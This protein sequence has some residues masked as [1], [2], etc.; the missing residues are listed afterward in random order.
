MRAVILAGGLGTRMAG[1]YPGLPKPLIPVGGK[2]VL[3]RQIETLVRQGITEITLVTGYMADRVASVFGDGS[4]YGAHIAYFAEETPLGTAGALYRMDLD[5]DFLLLSGDLVFDFDVAAML[6]FHKE[7]NALATLFAHPN[8]HPADSTLLE[9][10]ADERV[11]RFLPKEHRSGWHENLCNAGVQ[12]LSA[13]LFRSSPHEDAVDLDREV[14]RPALE[15]GRVFA[16]RSAEYVKDMGTPE[17][18]AAAERDLAAGLVAAKNKARPQRA[19]FLDRDGTLNVMGDFVTS[20]E[21]LELIP[22]AAQAVKRINES[23]FLA[24]LITNQPVIA[25]GECTEE[26]LKEIHN[27]LETLLGEEGAYLDAIYYCPHHPDGGYPGEIPE[28]KIVCDCRKPAPGLILRAVNDFNINLSA[29]YMVGDS[30]RDIHAAA[31]A[32]CMPVYLGPALPEGSPAN[33]LR[34]PDLKAFA[35]TL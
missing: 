10:D 11:L 28:L 30:W 6:A 12:I 29:S 34:F 13:Q 4:A 31:N 35:D 19:V 27:K 7:K 21:P 2:P 8:A 23:G 16:Y 25:R 14:L 33:T 15:T 18:L 26:T 22:G 3:T 32:G 1:L 24:I 5:G 20:P 9:T 17:R